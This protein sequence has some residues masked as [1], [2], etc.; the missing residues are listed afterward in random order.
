MPRQ[1]DLT[2]TRRRFLA[3]LTIGAGAALLAACQAQSPPAPSEPAKPAAPPAEKAPLSKVEGPA[4]APAKDAPAAATKAP[5]DWEKQ[6]QE[7]IE[8]AKKEGKVVL[9]GP[10]TPEVRTQVPARFKERF[11]IEVEYLGGRRGE[12]V[13]RLASERA[14]GVY[15]VDVVVGG[16]QTIATEF[17]PQKLI[18]PIRP[19]LIHPEVTDPTKWRPGKIWFIDPDDT[20]ALRL[21][22]SVSPILAINT[23]K[24]KPEEIK[25]SKDL[26]DPKFKGLI[27]QDDP[28]V[29]GSGSNLA[30]YLNQQLG[31]EFIR[32]LYV[33]QRAQ[34]TTDRRQLSDWLGR[35]VA[36]IVINPNDADVIEPLLRDGFPISVIQNLPDLPA[37]VT[38]GSGVMILLNKA[39]NPNAAKL[40]VN[41]L[42]SK[43]GMETYSKAEKGVPL[44][45]DVDD[46][47]AHDYQI[48]KPGVKYFDTY[49]WQ[50]T[51]SDKATISK[52]IKAML[53][54]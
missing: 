34:F 46:S 1:R 14:A 31:E 52:K 27:G 2:T 22:N 19:I 23:S 17:Y 11:G 16:A 15:T 41:W 36:P 13:V 54:Q 53:G 10:P 44:R 37:N 40:L 9:S 42:A 12:L 26:L 33:D 3:T 50:F 21:V 29:S 24:V 18:D 45:T 35:G 30:A 47:W 7:L 6:W 25:S 49:D 4:A 39:P 28:T 43:E 5:A 48:P 32:K 8:A 20:Y 51:L 38:A